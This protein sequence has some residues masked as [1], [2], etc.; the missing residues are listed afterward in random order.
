MFRQSVTLSVYGTGLR[1]KSDTTQK[2]LDSSG[3]LRNILLF[4]HPESL[5]LPRFC[6]LFS[7]PNQFLYY[8]ELH[9]LQYVFI[10]KR[11][12]SPC[13][14]EYLHILSGHSLGW[15]DFKTLAGV[16]MSGNYIS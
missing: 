1:S 3:M 13:K 16:N 5:Y 15:N 10:L 11:Y 14:S 9:G 12:G 6:T 7:K 8:S 2:K 4:S